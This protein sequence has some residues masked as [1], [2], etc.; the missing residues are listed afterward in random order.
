MI[1]YQGDPS[2][3][4]APPRGSAVAIGVFDGVHLGHRKVLSALQEGDEGLTKVAMTFGTHPAA[5]LSSTGAPSRLSTL[6]RRF[7]LFEEV[8]IERVAVLGFDE[9]MRTMA[10]SDFVQRFLVDGLDARCVVVGAGFHF[11]IDATGTTKTLREIGERLGFKVTVVDIACDDRT[12]IRSTTIR[13]AIEEG[14][15]VRAGAMLGRPYE[16]EGIVVPGDERGRDLGVSTAKISFPATLTVPKHGVYAV[17]VWIDGIEHR[18]VANL[19]LHTTHGVSADVLA[20]HVIGVERD[21]YGKQLRVGFVDRIRD[22]IE[23]TTTDDIATQIQDDIE[24]AKRISGDRA[25]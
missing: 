1:I 20:V 5:L 10:P 22:E 17:L 19:G 11:G 7:E 21:L 18:G 13:T 25:P 9:Q 23:F 4:E 15:V 16:L 14:D 2:G 3:W 6:K 12:E 8:G 24:T